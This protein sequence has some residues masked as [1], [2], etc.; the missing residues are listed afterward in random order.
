M[1]RRTFGSTGAHAARVDADLGR[2]YFTLVHRRG[3]PKA[4][5]AVARKLL[6]RRF[7]MLRDQIDYDEFR[8]R[9]RRR[10]TVAPA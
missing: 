8:R 4:K 10:P 9:G 3:R 2:T 5:V 1:P 7:I 6:V